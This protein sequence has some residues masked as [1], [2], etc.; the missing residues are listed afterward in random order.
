[1]ENR[2]VGPNEFSNMFN[3]IINAR[4]INCFLYY[5]HRV[6]TD[7]GVDVNNFNSAGLNDQSIDDLVVA[8]DDDNEW[9]IVK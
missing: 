3:T 7:G 6:L 5:V 2:D 8:E 1:M 9:L 4:N